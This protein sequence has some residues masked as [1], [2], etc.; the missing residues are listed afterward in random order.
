MFRKTD[1]AMIVV[2]LGV[3]GY[4]YTTKSET[5]DLRAELADV[6]SAILE[7]EHAI[8]ILRADW[9]LLTSPQRVQSLVTVFADQLDLVPN[10]PS[11]FV[12]LEDIPMRPQQSEPEVD[13][14][15]LLARIAGGEDAAITT[16]SIAP[17]EPQDLD[18]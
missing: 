10:D 1:I 9:S 15:T 11:R 13:I 18:Q 16:G 12:A 14:D 8:A 17:S 7:E 3:V 2:A 4:T 6:Q 5:K